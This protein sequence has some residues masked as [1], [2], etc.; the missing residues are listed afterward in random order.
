MQKQLIIIGGGASGFF[1][2]VN[3]AK[4]NPNLK[5]MLV[6]KQSKVLQKVKVS[7]G[8]RC[9]V[10]NGITQTSLL[11]QKYP[12]GKSF[13][14]NT[15]K[16]FTTTDTINWFEE[17]GVKLKTEIDGRVFPVSDSSQSIIDCLLNEV[18][19]YKIELKLQTDIIS[20]EKN[21]DY[22]L[23]ETKKNEYLKADFVYIAC[24]GFPK[25][26]QYDWLKKL[27]HKIDVPVPSL[28]TF[29]IPKHPLNDLMGVVAENAIV[30]IVGSKLQEQGPV[31]VTHWGLSGPAILRLS[32]WGAIELQQK[33]YNFSIIINW[34]GIN[35]N[36]VRNNWNTIRTKQSHLQLKNKNPFGLPTRLWDFILQTCQLSPEIKWSELPSKEQN[37]LINTLTT[38]EL[39]VNGKTTFKEEFV[40][41]GGIKL[42]EVDANTMQSKLVPQL[43]FGGEILNIDGITGGFN[44]QNAWTCGFVAANHFSTL[45]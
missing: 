3:A 35:E 8:G 14:K 45:L 34:L 19:K 25:I 13:L 7:G 39:M 4:L 36:E 1:C 24:G 22:F 42:D 27:G 33:N 21:N 41:S 32:A 5:I 11:V 28:F 2:A 20:I 44:F 29:N 9:N 38:H 6:E 43:F 26:E 10:T 12:R 17:R 37:K 40:T 23:L 16:Q 31:L 15:F 18:S 30:K